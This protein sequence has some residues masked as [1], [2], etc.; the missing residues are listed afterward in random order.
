MD[1]HDYMLAIMDI[2]NLIMDI[3]DYTVYALLA[4][5]IF[6]PWHVQWMSNTLAQ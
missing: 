3:H 4:F 2:H 6:V 1:I 5:H